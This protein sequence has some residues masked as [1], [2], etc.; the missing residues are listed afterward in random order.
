MLQSASPS[1]SSSLR[2]LARALAASGVEIFSEQESELRI[3]ERVRMHLMDSGVRVRVKDGGLE[4]LF[5]ATATRSAHPSAS[6][7]EL[8][9]R[10]RATTGNVALARGYRELA[11]ARRE[12]RDPMGPR[13][14]LDV[15][16]ELEY[17]ISLSDP[18]SLV[19]EV[20]W[21]LDLEKSPPDS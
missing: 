10:I 16:Y 1:F 9:S 15:F 8:F 7:D 6:P 3:A 20:R 18:A 4:V 19:D 2:A 17:A 21:A 13:R 12:A 14:V 11:E 5:V